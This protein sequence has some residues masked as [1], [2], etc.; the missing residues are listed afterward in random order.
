MTA[1]FFNT[2]LLPPP[3]LAAAAIDFA[4]DNLPAKPEG[5]FLG[6]GGSHPHITLCQSQIDDPFQMTR[7]ENALAKSARP[8]IIVGFSDFYPADQPEDFAYCGLACTP[9]DDLQQLHERVVAIHDTFQI[10]YR[11]KVEDNYFPH[12]T[13]LRYQ[14]GQTP[15]NPE[16]PE[17]FKKRHTG[18]VLAFGQSDALG[19]LLSVR[20]RFDKPDPRLT[21]SAWE[22]KP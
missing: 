6:S 10:A 22:L 19:Q 11:G 16:L 2:V 14:P 20:Q 21:L 3:N 15:L 17:I 5:Y 8:G 9:N 1:E 4:R 13:F 18:W 12:M 7:L